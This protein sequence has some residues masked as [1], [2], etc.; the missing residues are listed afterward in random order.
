MASSNNLPNELRLS[1][2]RC[3]NFMTRSSSIRVENT[4]LVPMAG[5][6]YREQRRKQEK[7]C[8]PLCNKVRM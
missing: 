7:A 4:F 1:T 6:L 5:I 3:F 2:A 8:I